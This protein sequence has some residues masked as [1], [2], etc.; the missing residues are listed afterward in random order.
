MKAIDLSLNDVCYYADI[1]TIKPVIIEGMIRSEDLRHIRIGF[2]GDP[3]VYVV[4][5]G[6]QNV[7]K[8]YFFSMEEAEKRQKKL[9]HQA[10][11]AAMMNEAKAEKDYAK[12]MQLYGIKLKGKSW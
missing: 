1:D 2:V 9:R 8:L 10:V 6:A 5:N 3:K 7:F 11:L 12:L 4:P